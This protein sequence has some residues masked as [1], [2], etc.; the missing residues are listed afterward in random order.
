MRSA[1]ADEMRAK[2]RERILGLTPS[3]RTELAQLLGDEAV[4]SSAATHDVSPANARPTLGASTAKSR[5]PHPK[6]PRRP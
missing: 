5:K 6:R 4:A 2:V 1:V 3:E